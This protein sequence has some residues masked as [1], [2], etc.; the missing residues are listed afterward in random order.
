MPTNPARR[1]T[2]RRTV[3]AVVAAVLVGGLGW[4][5]WVW[6]HP[7]LFTDSGIT[8]TFNPAPV[9]DAAAWGDIAAPADPKEKE[10][11]VLHGITAH[12]ATNTAHATARFAICRSKEPNSSVLNMSFSHPP[13]DYCESVRAV[14]EGTRFT[15]R[16]DREGVKLDYIVIIIE[17]TT[18]GVAHVDRVTMDYS[19]SWGHLRQH[20]KDSSKQDWIVKVS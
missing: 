6:T 13:A 20:G 17:P 1:W 19:R 18:P 14:T 11:L 2:W 16:P 9:K 4:A 7:T 8:S 10:T 12:F 3:T 5:G 15:I